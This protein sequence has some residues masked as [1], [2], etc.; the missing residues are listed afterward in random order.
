MA[1]LHILGVK[2]LMMQRERNMVVL[3]VLSKLAFLFAKIVLIFYGF[4]NLLGLLWF[5]NNVDAWSLSTGVLVGFSGIIA[6]FVKQDKNLHD[7]KFISFSTVT[8][9]IVTLV[10]GLQ[11]VIPSDTSVMA[12]IPYFIVALCYIVV[13]TNIVKHDGSNKSRGVDST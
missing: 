8:G 10:L 2:V 5:S 7:Q 12:G 6:S 3:S 4:V 9:C 13:I 11:Y 1:V